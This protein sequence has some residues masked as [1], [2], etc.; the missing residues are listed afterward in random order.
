MMFGALLDKWSIGFREASHCKD[1]TY[2]LL[3]ICF[4]LKGDLYAFNYNS[5]EVDSVHCTI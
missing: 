3:A 4:A 5:G 1:F 2:Q